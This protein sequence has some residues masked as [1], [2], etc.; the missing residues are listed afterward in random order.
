MVCEK[1]FITDFQELMVVIFLVFILPGAPLS[2]W[3]YGL[4]VSI[5]IF[6]SFD[7]YFF[8]QGFLFFAYMRL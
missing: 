7:H 8:R 6:E 3:F 1:L 4:I 5:K 2:C